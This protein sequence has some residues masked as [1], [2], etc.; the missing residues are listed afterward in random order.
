MSRL[1]IRDFS[2]AGSD[3]STP[4]ARTTAIDTLDSP[5]FNLVPEMPDRVV[6]VYFMA[7]D[8]GVEDLRADG[9]RT[10]VNEN[11]C[12]ALAAPCSSGVEPELVQ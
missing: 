6:A 8:E 4:E 2:T 3:L 10:F 12:A 5:T 9:V 7:P 1:S 11:L